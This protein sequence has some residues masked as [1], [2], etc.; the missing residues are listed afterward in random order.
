LL[1]GG[2]VLKDGPS[3]EVVGA[4]LESGTG[5]TAVREWTLDKAPG[6]DIVRMC[7]VR[8]KQHDT[9]S[10][11]VDIRY[12]VSIEIEYEVLKDGHVLSPACGFHNQEG[13]VIMASWER[14][15][16]PRPQGR[17]ITATQVPGNFFAEGSIT[18]G[19]SILTEDPYKVHA[20]ETPA[21]GFQVVDN[22]DPQIATARGNYAG[23]IPGVVRPLLHWETEAIGSL[24]SETAQLKT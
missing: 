18:V 22:L 16:E 17:Y 23:E 1:D 24:T 5:S 11:C 2:C 6:N 14:T 4:Y 13:V 12:P 19:A 9:V 20:N 3:H 15:R 7:G 21:V 8:V 10:D